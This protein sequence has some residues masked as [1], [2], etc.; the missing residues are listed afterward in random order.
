[1]WIYWKRYFKRKQWTNRKIAFVAILVATSVA[2]VLVFTSIAPIA[3]IP[4]FKLAAGG[5]PI[6]LTGYIFGPLVGV[7]TGVLS[8]SL[9]FAFRPVVWHWSYMFAWGVAGFV[10]GV[11]G[12]IMN[13][14]WKKNSEVEKQFEEKHNFVNMVGALVILGAIFAAVF[15][16]IFLEPD[17][18]FANQK[19]IKNKWLF[20]G[21]ALTGLSTMFLAIIIFRFTM[22]PKTFNM[23]VPIIAFSA[24]LEIITT[25]LL[26]IGDQSTLL[27]NTK[28]F[29][30]NLTAHI[31]ISPIK[32]WVNLTIIFFAYKVVSPLIYNKSNNGWD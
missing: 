3:A 16:F 29:M 31:L 4:S 6:K 17:S 11:I 18:T 13:R 1:M 28:S 8:D 25:P 26:T 5:L 24:L 22:K 21:I 23:V 30:D 9:S 12:Y 10:P 14:R 7:L 2:F 20:L 32:I 27:A 15:V 19:M